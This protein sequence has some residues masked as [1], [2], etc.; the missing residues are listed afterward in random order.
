MNIAGGTKDT[1]A[2]KTDGTV[3]A[4]GSN[5]HGQLGEGTTTDRWTTLQVQ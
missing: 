4:W 1:L 3:W 2:R 5:G